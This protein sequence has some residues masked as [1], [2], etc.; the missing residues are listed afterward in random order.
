MCAYVSK[1]VVYAC[2]E[3]IPPS[4]P[5]GSLSWTLLAGLGTCCYGV[6]EEA[7]LGLGP[8]PKFWPNFGTRVGPNF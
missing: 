8:G 5:G 1:C 7:G 3:L 2:A 4:N 6:V